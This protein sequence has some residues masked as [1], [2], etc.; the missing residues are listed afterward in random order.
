[1]AGTIFPTR[2]RVYQVTEASN[3]S[4]IIKRRT[5]RRTYNHT[6]RCRTCWVWFCWWL[7]L[8]RR[9]EHFKVIL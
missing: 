5:T 9:N 8:C 4:I 3:S 2:S 1:M 7:L 6:T